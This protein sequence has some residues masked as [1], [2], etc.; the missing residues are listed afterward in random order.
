LGLIYESSQDSKE[1]SFSPGGEGMKKIER[2][3]EAIQFY[4]S[5]FPEQQERERMGQEEGISYARRMKEDFLSSSYRTFL[6]T[7]SHCDHT[8]LS[9]F[10]L[11]LTYCAFAWIPQDLNESP[12]SSCSLT[13]L[14][15]SRLILLMKTSDWREDL[16]ITS[17]VTNKRPGDT[18][19]L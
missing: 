12:S 17:I 15:S 18:I 5:L 3:R 16:W 6:T 10:F 8:H 14:A 2:D 4:E 11:S 1:N 7:V 19:H 9:L 13:S